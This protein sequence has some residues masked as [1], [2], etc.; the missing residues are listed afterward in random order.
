MG[1]MRRNRDFQ[2]LVAA[3][4]LALGPGAYVAITLLGAGGGQRTAVQ[5]ANVANSTLYGY[6]V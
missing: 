1:S 3:T 5:M 2:N 4:V 6:A